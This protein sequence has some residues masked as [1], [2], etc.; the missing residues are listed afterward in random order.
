MTM[1]RDDIKDEGKG[2]VPTKRT[3]RD[4]EEGNS[5]GMHR[6]CNNHYMG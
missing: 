1:T 5:E 6:I 3:P 2:Q 4:E